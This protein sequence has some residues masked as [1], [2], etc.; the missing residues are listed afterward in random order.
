MTGKKV[1]SGL[2]VL[3]VGILL[4]ACIVE[5]NFDRAPAWTGFGGAPINRTDVVGEAQGWQN[6]RLT[7]TLNVVNGYIENVRIFGE[8]ETPSY[9]RDLIQIAQ[10]NA[11]LL[12]SFDFL[13]GMS[14][15]TVTRNAIRDAGRDAL[16]IA[17]AAVP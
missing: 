5:Y 12:N 2:V 11:A 1:S 16:R 17:G 13:D 9:T 6:G 3:A 8:R 4:S 14:G 15:A 10:R 7:V